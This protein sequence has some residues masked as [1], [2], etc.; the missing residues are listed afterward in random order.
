MSFAER[1]VQ[2]ALID[3]LSEPDLG[4]T[5][6][7]GDEL[8]R[9]VDQVLVEQAVVAA[10]VRLNPVIAEDESR[11]DEVLPKLRA[12]ILAVSDDG[13]LRANER[14]LSWLR[15]HETHKFVGTDDFVPVWLIDFDD[16]RANDLVVADEVT[17]VGVDERRFDLVLFVNGIP[18]VVGETKSPVRG[19]TW[20]SGAKD[21]HH[22]YGRSAR[23]S[24]CRTC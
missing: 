11:V 8:A 22:A 13:L 4:W 12:A 14:L 1:T 10:L 3:R 20:F 2:D 17:Y 6:V 5:H 21:V 23:G 7:R 24:S 18:L 9:S 19:G 16:P 15:G